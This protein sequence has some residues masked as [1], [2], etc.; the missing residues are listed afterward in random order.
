M[1]LGNG[2]AQFLIAT[3]GIPE[4]QQSELLSPLLR[5]FLSCCLQTDEARRWS[6]QE[7]LQHPFVTSAKPTSSL[8]PLVILVNNWKEKTGMRQ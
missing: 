7:L 4:L 1:I 6:A 8:A 5:H 2:R 3:K